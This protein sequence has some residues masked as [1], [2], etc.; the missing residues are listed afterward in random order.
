MDYVKLYTRVLTHPKWIGLSPKA[1]VLLVQAWMWAGDGETDGHVPDAAR[2]LVGHPPATAQE[3]EA[4]GWWHRNG[5]GWHLHDWSD[6]QRT[7][8]QMAQ[9]RAGVRQRVNRHRERRRQ[10][11]AA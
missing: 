5:S 9:A 2:A 10:E 1:K 4:A 3:L 11:E 7:K 8:D 6:H